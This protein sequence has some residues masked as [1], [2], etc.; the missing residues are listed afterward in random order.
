MSFFKKFTINYRTRNDKHSQQIQEQT[1]NNAS[2]DQSERASEFQ[3]NRPSQQQ[4][5]FSIISQH[6]ITTISNKDDNKR[7][8]EAQQESDHSPQSPQNNINSL[9]TQKNKYS[10]TPVDNRRSNPTHTENICT[11]EITFTRDMN[12][13]KYRTQA[14]K[15]DGCYIINVNGREQRISRDDAI[16]V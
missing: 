13:I 5:T 7:E 12:T 9:S 1:T 4:N 16:E 3:G 8:M 10:I 2:L 14:K 15:K 11:I 6:T